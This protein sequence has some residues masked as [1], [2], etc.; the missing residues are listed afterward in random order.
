[1]KT[2][3]NEYKRLDFSKIGQRVTKSISTNEALKD[4]TPI[5]WSDDVLNGRK[6]INITLFTKED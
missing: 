5:N 3:V 1:M 2:V 4:V 6:K